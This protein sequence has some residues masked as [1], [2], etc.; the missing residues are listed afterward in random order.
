MSRRRL[1]LAIAAVLGLLVAAAVLI[2]V[3]NLRD[4]PKVDDA[5]PALAATPALVE[6]GAY[7]AR[8]GNCGACHT[9][10]GGAPYAGGPGVETPFGTVYA[11]NLTPDTKTGIG[12]W[13]AA[14]FWRAM[15]NGRSRDGRLLYP[16]FPYPNFTQITREDSDALYA[17]LRSLAPVPQPNKPHALRFPYDSQLSLAVWRALFFSPGTHKA[18]PT[19]TAEWNRGSYLVHGLGH[20]N[21]CHGGRNILGATSGKLELGGGLIPMQSWYAPSLVSPAEAGVASWST[22]EVVAL[23]KSGV[24][25]KGSVL[26]PMAEVVYRSTQFLS[27]T[28]LQAMAVYLRAL[29]QQQPPVDDEVKK[30]DPAL[31]Q[32]GARLYDQNCAQCHGERGE[33]SPGAYPALAGNRAVTMDA[34]ANLVRIVIYG[35][36]LPATAGNPRPFGMPPFS[37]QLDDNDVAA[38]LSYIRGSWGNNASMV[39]PIEAL[40]YR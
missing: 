28:D 39:L 27:D 32:R 10:R 13:S 3:L 12:A 26:G 5:A 34:P 23:L 30:R 18:D 38:V 40:R 35:G 37:Q 24:A 9:A 14:H 1:G 31:M 20:C 6:R 15:H 21:A 29:P 4:E 22:P 17:Y 11:S 7:L 25:P 36:F 16:A 8:A 2:A 19:R 33:G